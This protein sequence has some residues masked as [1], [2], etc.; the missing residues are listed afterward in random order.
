MRE[1]ELEFS[2]KPIAVV[3]PVASFR[4][5][6]EKAEVSV[7]GNKFDI[8]SLVRIRREPSWDRN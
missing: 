2:K 8:Y 5:K 1:E 4:E 6:T 3:N 7:H